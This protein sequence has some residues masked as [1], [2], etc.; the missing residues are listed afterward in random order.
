MDTKSKASNKEKQSF[1][2]KLL[3]KA[4]FCSIGPK[5]GVGYVTKKIK[6]RDREIMEQLTSKDFDH[7]I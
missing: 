4:F 5:G 7:R 6:G 2:E 1:V 3:T